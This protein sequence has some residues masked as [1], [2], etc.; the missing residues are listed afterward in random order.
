MKKV[1]LTLVFGAFVLA[2]GLSSASALPPFDKEWKAKYLPD[3]APASLKDAAGTAKCNVC[4]EGTSKKMRN[5]YGKAVGKYL[6]KADFEAV[7][8][9]PEKSKKYIVEGLEKAEAEKSASGKSF[10]E[11]IKAGKGPWEG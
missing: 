9:D 5:A 11:L 2:L 10:G 3:S 1:C 7:K 6:T 8:A 4:H